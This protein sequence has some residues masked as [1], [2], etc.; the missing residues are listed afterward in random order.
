MVLLVHSCC[1]NYI[2][3]GTFKSNK[4]NVFYNAMIT[5]TDGMYHTLFTHKIWSLLYPL[6]HCQRF[7]VFG[8]RGA[9]KNVTCPCRS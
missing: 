5:S 8:A 9:F 2:N 7:L 1:Y 4:S 6:L 3:V